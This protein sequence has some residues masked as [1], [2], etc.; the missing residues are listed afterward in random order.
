MYISTMVF[1]EPH[2]TIP[3]ITVNVAIMRNNLNYQHATLV[4]K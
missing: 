4:H 2:V 1:I 3:L